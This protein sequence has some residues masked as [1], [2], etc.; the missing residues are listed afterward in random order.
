MS[1]GRFGGRRLW[2]TLA[3]YGLW[4]VL[5]GFFARSIDFA[6]VWS[7]FGALSVASLLGV[8]I[9]SGLASVLQGVRFHFLL[10]TNSRMLQQIYLTFALQAGNLFLPLRGGELLRLFYLRRACP[11]LPLRRLVGLTLLD[12][13]IEL[14]AL[15]P[16]VALLSVIF[17]H[18]E[19]FA[20]LRRLAAPT[21]LIGGLLAGLLVLRIH[22]AARKSSQG[23]RVRHVV[24]AFA[25]S[26]AYWVC[27]WLVFFCVIPDLRLSLVLLVAVS[28]SFAVP[29]LPAGMGTYE[30][31][32][33]FVG[34][35]GGLSNESLLAAALASHVLQMLSTLVVGVPLL[36]RWGWPRR[37]APDEQSAAAVP[38]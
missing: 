38:L 10:A 2:G 15:L 6:K 21:L 28:A 20:S 13:L 4:I 14:L 5:L 26:L 1:P 25:A 35:L 17:L 31:A 30:A 37:A 8:V 22:S 29:G 3:L 9:A 24:A 36:F 19:R 7:A 34:Q 32:F 23:L 27:S 11:E 18:D 16:V 33:V 12:K